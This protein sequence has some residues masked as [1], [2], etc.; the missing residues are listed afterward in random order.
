MELT[1]TEKAYIAGFLDGEG[2]ITI[3]KRNR[4][5]VPLYVPSIQITNTNQEILKW[6]KLKVRKGRI[7]KLK[8]ESRKSFWKD[9][10]RW[11]LTNRKDMF[12]FLKMIFPYLQVKEKQAF[13][14]F[15]FK[16]EQNPLSNEKRIIKE[17]LYQQMKL[18]NKKGK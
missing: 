18:L 8:G 6:I 11:I 4:Y 9:T 13:I 12:E 17:K 3:F 2:C 16:R 15:Q 1:E 5:K 10:Y 14:I 7:I